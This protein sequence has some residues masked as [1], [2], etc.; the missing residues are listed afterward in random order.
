M[1][2]TFASQ[3]WADSLAVQL[4]GDAQ[5]RTESVTWIFGPIVVAI[6]ADPEHG[7]EATAIRIDVFEGDVQGVELIPADS[8]D[9]LPFVV[10]G[11]LARWKSVFA[12]QLAIGDGILQSRLR[13]RGD[14]PTLT[15]HRALLDAVARVGASIE[16]TWQD[17]LVDAATAG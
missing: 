6:D 13:V 15:R 8:A 7:L 2:V 1:S 9:R 11:S 3:E 14:L 12:G 16:T 17:E 10:G 4:R 5:V